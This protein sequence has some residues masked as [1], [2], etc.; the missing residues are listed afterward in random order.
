M[1]KFLLIGFL[2]V[3]SFSFGQ[4]YNL[5]I[6]D[7]DFDAYSKSKRC[8]TKVLYIDVTSGNGATRVYTADPNSYNSGNNDLVN[9]PFSSPITKIY[10]RSFIHER[11]IADIFG[12]CNGDTSGIIISRNI[13]NGCGSGSFSRSHDGGQAKTSINFKYEITPNITLTRSGA[14]NNIEADQPFNINASSG[15]PP[16]LYNWEYSLGSSGNWSSFPGTSGQP[17]MSKSPQDFLSGNYIGQAIHFRIS[18]CSGVSSNIV[19]YKIIPSA[20][21]VVIHPID[22]TNCA[23]AG[24]SNGRFVAEFDRP[25]KSGEKISI[26]LSRNDPLG[27]MGF[28]TEIATSLDSNNSFTWPTPLEVADFYFIEYKAILGSDGSNPKTSREFDINDPP[29]ISFDAVE[30]T[31]V[32]CFD[33]D[34]GEVLLTVSGGAGGFE[35]EQDGS[36][37]WIP[38]E[39]AGSHTVTNLITGT[40][41]FRIRDINGCSP[42]LGGAEKTIDISITQPFEEVYFNLVSSVDASLYGSSDGEVTVDV[43][44]GTPFSNGSYTYVWSGTNIVNP[45]GNS[46]GVSLGG[47]VYRIT[48]SNQ[49]FGTYRLNVFDANYLKSNAS[50]TITCRNQGNFPIGGIAAL[51]VDIQRTQA[52]SCNPNNTFGNPSSDGQ[53][54]ATASGGV[55]P[56][57]Y[58]WKKKNSSGVWQVIPGANGTTI[59][60]LSEGEYAFN[61][62][63]ANGFVAGIYSGSSIIRVVDATYNLVAPSIPQVSL[64]KQ[65]VYCYQ[66]SDGWVKAN[67]SGGTPPYSY[68][69]NTG[70]TTEQISSL[71]IGTYS[72]D[73]SDNFGCQVATASITL[74][75]P[76]TAFGIEHTFVSP[77]F[78]G[79]TNGSITVTATGGTPNN[80]GSYIYRWENQM[81]Q[82]LSAQV[83]SQIITQT[84]S[85]TSGTQT[86][87]LHRITLNNIGAGDYFLDFQDRNYAT[88]TTSSNCG[89]SQELFTLNEPPPLSVDLIQEQP[90]SC[91]SSNTY[92]DPN[93]DGRLFAFA[94]GGVPL[95]AKVNGGLAYYYTWKKQDENGLWQIIP[96]ETSTVLSGLVAGSYAVNIEDANGIILGTYTNNVLTQTLDVSTTLVEPPL[97]QIT[98]ITNQGTY[99][100]GGTDG[101]ANATIIGGTPPYTIA[102]SSG[103]T[104]SLASNL[105]GGIHTIQVIDSRGCHVASSTF[106]DGP[107][108][109]LAIEYT[110]FRRPTSTG[111][112][113]GWIEAEVTGGTSFQ[114]SSYTYLWSSS[115][116][117]I[118]NSQ[119]QSS[120]LGGKFKVRLNDLP[121]GEYLLTIAD[122][123]FNLT[124][125]NSNCQIIASPFQ[126]Y[127]PLEASI[128][129]ERPISCNTSNTFGNTFS[130]GILIATVSGGLPFT[131][132][133]PYI[134]NWK[135]QNSNG[136]FDPLP[137]LNTSR[138]LELS[139]GRYALNVED[140]LGNIIGIYEG[141]TLVSPAD[142]QF[143]FNDPEP[144][145]VNLSSTP[146]FCE[147]DTNGTAQTQISGGTP[148]YTLEWS[149]GATTPYIDN[150]FAGT[151]ILYITDARGCEATGQ[152]IIESPGG[153]EASFV[154]KSNPTCFEGN[155]G[156]I[157][158][159][160]SG[161]VPPYQYLWNNG[162]TDVL[163]TNLT[164]GTYFFEVTDV[165]NC[166]AYFSTSLVDPEPIVIDLGEDRTLCSG[167][168]H[169]IDITTADPNASYRWEADNG[170]SS[171]AAVVSLTEAGTYTA[172]YTTGLGC[173]GSDTINIQ[174]ED[175][176]IDAQFLITTQAFANEDIILIN[177]SNPISAVTE[178]FVP[179]TAQIISQTNESLILNF[180]TSGVF[181]I[182]LRSFQGDC[183]EEYTKQIIVGTADNLVDSG[184]TSTPYILNFEVYP[185]P[186]TGVF[187]ADVELAEQGAISL[188][189]F[190]LA[191]GSLID[192]RQ[193]FGQNLY[194][195][196]YQLNLSS[197]TY[198][199]VLETAVNRALRKVVIQ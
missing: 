108:E 51:V 140:S 80:D 31:A 161:G 95:E 17:T 71:S 109:P 5:R 46:R 83:S 4:S 85:S 70:A 97:L 36:G 33:G 75:Q 86:K 133:S 187:S 104:T 27:V 14:S 113:D 63:D 142:V 7:Y 74:T 2:S 146:I 131:S 151:Y 186:N 190:S 147:S 185:N 57:S 19:T 174:V 6:Y 134:Y 12:S 47:G 166:K 164:E 116:G 191:T 192:H 156:S 136:Q 53:L 56:Y 183:Y 94:Q 102:W 48:L 160:I 111:A 171:T 165:N 8:G 112:T 79:G 138:A 198:F 55:R 130:D 118:L 24:I 3:V 26:S 115:D 30:K 21:G 162:S 16:T 41:N 122:A 38:F 9:K 101:W 76:E 58:T 143:E 87:T 159:A 92:G 25:L 69:W 77:A 180:N 50:S 22:N 84:V 179:E 168:E 126:I 193:A 28:T 105:G 81:G 132:G 99:C 154:E 176:E 145:I 141:F 40:Y 11:A 67:A 170:F 100:Y 66:G 172:Y 129:I 62:T 82:N 189:I 195:M 184:D 34:D 148:P 135:K 20:P 64:S 199:V 89:I 163:N 15:F 114:D 149:N 194:T 119:T 155:D 127:E 13:S 177:T 44:G 10:F 42:Q 121:L 181:D 1:K 173:E 158:V 23:V 169:I 68:R 157:E 32:N 43:S 197:G 96:N 60:N 49:P 144:I 107:Q 54:R 52:I 93:D 65:D 128:A 98:G 39:N 178:W 188:R 175:V 153:L 120:T 61:V 103:A 78:T 45:T 123:N 90:V 182:I 150:L 106:I 29:P 137:E 125:T 72:V 152:V 110:D 59:S 18:F 73:V 139:P 37:V 167:Q 196:S 35:Y 117:T 124:S 91:N 88:A